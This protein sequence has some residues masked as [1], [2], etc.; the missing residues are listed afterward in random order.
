MKRISTLERQAMEAGCDLIQQTDD[1]WQWTTYRTCCGGFRT[2]AMAAKDYL[3][4]VYAE[5]MAQDLANW[6]I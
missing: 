4:H 6:E 1:L 3:R 2:S 5:K